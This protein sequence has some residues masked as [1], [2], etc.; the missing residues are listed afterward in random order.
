MLM[1]DIDRAAHC[2]LDSGCG[3]ST[4]ERIQ[5]TGTC[6]TKK[7]KSRNFFI[8][9]LCIYSA[10]ALR[11]SRAADVTPPTFTPCLLT[12]FPKTMAARFAYLR[13]LSGRQWRKSAAAGAASSNLRALSTSAMKNGKNKSIETIITTHSD[14]Y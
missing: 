6:S 11:V 12:R 2:I 3:T 14:F 13:S 5:D 10:C 8:N 4:I 1:H 7:S 9:F